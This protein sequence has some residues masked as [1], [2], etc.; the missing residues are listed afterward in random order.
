[1]TG[2]LKTFVAVV[3]LAALPGLSGCLGGGGGGSTAA[4]AAQM[5]REPAPEPMA[6]PAADPDP[7]PMADP[8]AAR[9]PAPAQSGIVPADVWGPGGWKI[10]DRLYHVDGESNLRPTPYDGRAGSDTSG[11][12]S[13]WH[14]GGWYNTYTRVS[15]LADKSGIRVTR[16]P[17][18]VDP[19]DRDDPINIDEPEDNG[20]I[21]VF[22]K[23]GSGVVSDVETDGAVFGRVEWDDGADDG[24]R[25]LSWGWWLEYRGRNFI[26]DASRALSHCAAPD[27]DIASG[28]LS[29]VAGTLVVDGP[30]FR[31]PPTSLPERGSIG[32]YR[33]P[34]FGLF[35][36]AFVSS[37][38]S[39]T[40]G[41]YFAAQNIGKGQAGSLYTGEFTGSTEIT[42]NYGTSTTA[43]RVV[44]DIRIARMDGVLT[45]RGTG[46][47]EN[48]V[49]Q[50]DASDGPAFRYSGGLRRSYDHDDGSLVSVIVDM[51]PD[52]VAGVGARTN[53]LDGN[54]EIVLSNVAGAGGHPRRVAGTF[55]ARI[56]VNNLTE[57]HYFAGVYVAPLVGTQ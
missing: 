16:S 10:H 28:C 54:M 47:S 22:E 27:R 25:W 14:S 41:S 7:A 53:Q 5:P 20:N 51:R 46:V 48:L 21:T 18:G 57:A 55:Y 38:E 12:W 19:F 37:G 24:G 49:R 29:N 31:S 17:L 39:A 56:G 50:F 36:S 26:A 9:P 32:T 44:A 34:A 3:A 15:P 35:S 4:P 1:M 6:E 30:E 13:P 43:S 42:M 40:R 11:P 52:T 33:G 2:Y 8:A 45:N 23:R